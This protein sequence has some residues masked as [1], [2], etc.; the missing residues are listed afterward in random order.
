M[1]A[2]IFHPS[3]AAAIQNRIHHVSA[4]NL[5]RWGKMTLPQMLTH[6]GIQLRLALGKIPSSSFEGP[7]IY[8]TLP[9]RWLALY[10]F[11]WPKGAATPSEMNMSANHAT[12][13]ETEQ[14]KTELLLLLEEV[15]KRDSLESHPFFGRMNQQDW[16]RLIW[17]HLDH[18]LRQFNA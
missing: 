9:G 5:R 8:R 16:G 12:V 15:L 4:D 18:H 3:D 13:H 17:K 14:A 1:K 2:N 6:C 10:A 7:A 11:P